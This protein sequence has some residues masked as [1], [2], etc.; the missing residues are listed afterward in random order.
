MKTKITMIKLFFKRKTAMDLVEALRS[1]RNIVFEKNNKKE[2]KLINQKMTKKTK[3][4]I[5]R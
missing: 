3:K 4:R 2:K 1:L 5:N